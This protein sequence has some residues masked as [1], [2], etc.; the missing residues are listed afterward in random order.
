MTVKDDATTSGDD[1]NGKKRQKYERPVVVVYGDIRDI[2]R[3]VNPTSGK[4]DGGG[5]GKT[6]T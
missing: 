5:G 2:T 4:N 3:N 6:K 1:A